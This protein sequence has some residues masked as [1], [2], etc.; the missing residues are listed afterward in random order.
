MTL[1]HLGLAARFASGYL[2]QRDE[3][4]PPEQQAR[5]IVPGETGDNADLHAWAEVFLPGAGWVGLDPTSG[6]LAGADHIPLACTLEPAS[7]APITGTVGGCQVEFSYEM[8]L[9]P[10]DELE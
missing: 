1:R 7:S 5:R 4:R 10:T 3:D 9:R 2:V 8:S 6:L